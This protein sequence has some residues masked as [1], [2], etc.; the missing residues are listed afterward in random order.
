MSQGATDSSSLST[1]FMPASM[2]LNTSDANESRLAS[3]PD[4][5]FAVFS[6]FSWSYSSIFLQLGPAT[7]SYFSTFTRSDWCNILGWPQR[8]EIQIKTQHTKNHP[9][10]A[11]QK[12]PGALVSEWRPHTREGSGSP[13]NTLNAQTHI[14]TLWT[15]HHDSKETNVSWHSMHSMHSMLLGRPRTARTLRVLVVPRPHLQRFATWR[16]WFAIRPFKSVWLSEAS[17]MGQ[18]LSLSTLVSFWCAWTPTLAFTHWFYLK[19]TKFNLGHPS[20]QR[21]FYLERSPLS[22]QKHCGFLNW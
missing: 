2:A 22:C 14:G 1:A 8:K 9:K 16:R 7:Y 21:S 10:K 6:W 15:Q 18:Q 17:N 19:E 20:C 4:L 13:C 11:W 3:F 12:P 5:C